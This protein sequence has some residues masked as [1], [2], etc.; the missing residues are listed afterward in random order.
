MIV[1]LTRTSGGTAPQFSGVE[2]DD[3]FAAQAWQTSGHR[4]GRFARPLSSTERTALRRALTAAAS[5]PPAPPPAL[6]PGAVTEQITADGLD[7]LLDAHRPPSGG[8]CDLVE[9]LRTLHQDLAD[10]PVAAV[11]L[12][13]TAPP[14]TAR[15]RHVG[16]QPLAVRLGSLTL[17]ATVFDEDS[18]IVD[19]VS[20]RI[21]APEPDG[22]VAPGW[23]LPLVDDLAVPEPV[24]GGFLTVTVGPAEVD[25]LGDGVLRRAEFGWM[26][27]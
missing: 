26:S 10:S 15:L 20:R 12:E 18:G 25:V 9:L 22:S 1:R 8:A 14:L 19:S 6:R 21:P 27:E 13:V 4:V 23:S 24:E 16:T 17:Q 7:L 11:E 2:I 5:A 3:G